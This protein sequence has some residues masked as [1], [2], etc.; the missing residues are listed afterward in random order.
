M[1]DDLAARDG[2]DETGR[3]RAPRAS[4]SVQGDSPTPLADRPLADREVPIEL[5]RTSDMVH[6]WLDGELPRSALRGI[7]AARHVEFW[8]RVDSE[9]ELRR[10]VRAPVGFVERVMEA[11]P[12]ATPHTTAPWWSRQVVMNP[13]VV[14][15]AAAGLLALGTAL[16][17]AMRMR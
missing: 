5:A 11:L 4:D 7:D 1:L 2:R 8:G 15:A 12:A 17:A 9:L 13:L 16:G 14:A 3:P 6:A 10:E